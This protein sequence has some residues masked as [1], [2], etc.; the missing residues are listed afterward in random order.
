MAPLNKTERLLKSF[1]SVEIKPEH[2]NHGDEGPYLRDF[3]VPASIAG[4]LIRWGERHQ[5]VC[6]FESSSGRS[7]QT[8][9][10]QPSFLRAAVA[11]HIEI[12]GV[13][14][15]LDLPAALLCFA[16]QKI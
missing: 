6:C 5:L 14:G 4:S 1:A 9:A 15:L 7:N 8:Y 16:H 11:K 3:G 12:F 13:Q 2:L 10:W